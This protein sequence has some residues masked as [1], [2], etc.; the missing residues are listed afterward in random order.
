MFGLSVEHLLVL[1]VAALFVLGPQRLPEAASWLARTIHKARDFAAGAQ[2]QLKA[3]LGPEFHDLRKPLQDLQA[4]R[5]FNPNA[6]LSRYLLDEPTAPVLDTRTTPSGVA[7]LST[8][9]G[10]AASGA[11]LLPGERPPVD[12][13]AT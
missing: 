2:E 13:E 1:L 6:A 12:L 9:T 10:V 3:E 11:P 5:E 4:L 8:A 7:Q